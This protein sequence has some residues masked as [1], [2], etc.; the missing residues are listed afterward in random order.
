MARCCCCCCWYYCYAIL[1]SIVVAASSGGK[2]GEGKGAGTGWPCAA[3]AGGRECEAHGD[4]ADG[5]D[6][7]ACP[8][9]RKIEMNGQGRPMPPFICLHLYS[10]LSDTVYTAK[11]TRPTP[12]LRVRSATLGPL[13]RSQ[14]G[15]GD[16]RESV[17]GNAGAMFADRRW[18]IT[19]LGAHRR[20][21]PMGR[22]S[23][24]SEHMRSTHM[25]AQ[26]D[27]KDIHVCILQA[28]PSEEHAWGALRER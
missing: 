27:R 26:P 15:N 20:A 25:P 7:E 1:A 8:G 2:E 22:A 28:P 23:L 3:G 12:R 13:R 17:G 11:G 5:G 10:R 24:F 6:R 4:G 9:E 14:R 16:T 18:R 21:V 19:Q